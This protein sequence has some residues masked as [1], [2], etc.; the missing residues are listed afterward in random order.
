M[1]AV[2]ALGLPWGLQAALG[3]GITKQLCRQIFLPAAIFAAMW[4]G[5]P[6]VTCLTCKKM[7]N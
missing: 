7:K 2:I 4:S 5:C 3:A 1:S 6:D